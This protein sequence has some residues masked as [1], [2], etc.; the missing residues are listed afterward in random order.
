M[1]NTGVIVMDVDELAEMKVGE[2]IDEMYVEHKKN[3]LWR[4]GIQQSAF[5]LAVY[6]R[7]QV[8]GGF[9]LSAID[10]ILPEWMKRSDRSIAF[11]YLVTV[12]GFGLE[13]D[14]TRTRETAAELW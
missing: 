1:Y 13:H 12:V 14:G 9:V 3:K 8:S 5:I 7:I 2:K 10:T 11:I 6:H 4:K